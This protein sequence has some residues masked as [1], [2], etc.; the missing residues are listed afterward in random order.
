MQIKKIDKNTD[1]EA[2]DEA[3]SRDPNKEISSTE[4]WT[5]AYLDSIYVIEQNPEANTEVF[6]SSER[7]LP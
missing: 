2:A 1:L 6:K 7:N 4:E 3:L 5:A